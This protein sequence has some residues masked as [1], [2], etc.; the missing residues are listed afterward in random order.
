[1]FRRQ[2][3]SASAGSCF[4]RIAGGTAASRHGGPRIMRRGNASL[5]VDGLFAVTGLAA[6]GGDLQSTGYNPGVSGW[7]IRSTGAAEFTNLVVRSWLVDGAVTDQFQAI[8]VGPFAYAGSPVVVATLDL[9]AV[10]RGN[11]YLRGIVFEARA[12]GSGPNIKNTVVTL[13]RRSRQLGGAFNAWETITT[14]TLDFNDLAWEVRQGDGTLAGYYDD[15]EYRLK[16]RNYAGSGSGST[17]GNY[18][19]NVYLTVTRTTK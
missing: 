1:M 11:L 18:L 3:V 17:T 16:Y 9:A 8:A 15:Y 14:W 12:L 7:R 4:N 6:F 2:S 13:D 19:R 5:L 10:P